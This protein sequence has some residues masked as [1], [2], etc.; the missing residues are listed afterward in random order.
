MSLTGILFRCA[1]DIDPT[2][3]DAN[4]WYQQHR[5]E[6]PLTR[7]HHTGSRQ[8][9]SISSALLTPAYFKFDIQVQARTSIR[10]E[11]VC[12]ISSGGRAMAVP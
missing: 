6:L 4:Q 9:S 5:R 2:H 7:I 8:E 12:D 11:K 3:D 10:E 1:L